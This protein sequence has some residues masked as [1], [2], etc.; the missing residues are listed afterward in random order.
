MNISTYGKRFQSDGTAK[1]IDNYFSYKKSRW[2]TFHFESH[3]MLIFRLTISG[4]IFTSSLLDT[5]V[6]SMTNGL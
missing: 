2:S 1:E 6:L 5:Y 4:M 3:E